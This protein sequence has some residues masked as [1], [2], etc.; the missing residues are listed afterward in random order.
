MYSNQAFS[1]GPKR[2]RP[3]LVQR[4]IYSKEGGGGGGGEGGGG[5]GGG[6]RENIPLLDESESTRMRVHESWQ[7]R[8][9]G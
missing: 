9:L 3:I 1:R 6:V 8:D 5:G 2:G 4:Y 7:S